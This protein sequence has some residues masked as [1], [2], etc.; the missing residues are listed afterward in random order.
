MLEKAPLASN[1]LAY[2]I[3]V[4]KPGSPSN[5]L[6]TC[7]MTNRPEF[8]RRHRRLRNIQARRLLAAHRSIGVKNLEVNEKGSGQ[9]RTPSDHDISVDQAG[10]HGDAVQPGNGIGAKLGAVFRSFESEALRA[11]PLILPL[12]GPD[13]DEASVGQTR[14]CG[15]YRGFDLRC[16]DLAFR[17]RQRVLVEGAKLQLRLSPGRLLSPSHGKAQAAFD[18]RRQLPSR[19]R[20][21]RKVDEKLAAALGPVH[22]EHLAPDIAAAAILPHHDKLRPAKAGDGRLAL[23]SRGR[24][25][26]QYLV[27][28]FLPLP[29]CRSKARHQG[30]RRRRSGAENPATPRQSVRHEIVTHVLG[31]FCQPCV[32]AGQSEGSGGE[33]GIRT[34][35]TVSRIHAFQASALSHSAIPPESRQYSGQGSCDNP[36]RIQFT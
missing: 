36:S 13:D 10:H 29:A 33:S 2:A 11:D 34:H 12:V 6:L 23:I 22:A 19:P 32:R 14:H 30:S 8:E 7:A 5:A 28:R 18:D 16:A 27:H 20:L 17:A 24:R 3:V 35:D 9:A 26:D 31:T 21:R 1:T 4:S 25:V 15:P